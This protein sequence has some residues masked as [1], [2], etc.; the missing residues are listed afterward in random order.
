MSLPRTSGNLCVDAVAF[1]PSVTVGPSDWTSPQ[2]GCCEP[3]CLV[4]REVFAV[5]PFATGMSA[6]TI[7]G[8]ALMEGINFL[9]VH[10]F[11][12]IK[13]GNTECG[14]QSTKKPC[15]GCGVS[16][17]QILYRFASEGMHRDWL[18][19]HCQSSDWTFSRGSVMRRKGQRTQSSLNAP[20]RLS[21]LPISATWLSPD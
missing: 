6:V 10:M 16:T 12:K 4:Q 21:L 19:C 13:A 7:T 20:R 18:W 9:W 2:G 15:V 17:G 5:F 8:V 1:V 3:K 11:L 14:G